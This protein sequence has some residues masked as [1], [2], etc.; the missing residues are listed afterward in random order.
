VGAG[1]SSGVMDAASDLAG[2]GG[3]SS[4]DATTARDGT[5]SDGSIR[6]A[7]TGDVNVTTQ[8]PPI[9]PSVNTPCA[10]GLRDDCG[11][12]PRRKGH[13]FRM[14]C[15]PGLVCPALGDCFDEQ[16]KPQVGATCPI[17]QHDCVWSTGLYCRCLPDPDGG[18]PTWDCFPPSPDCPITPLNKGQACD[19]TPLTCAYGTCTLG[20]KVTTSCVGGT[21][22]W[23]LPVCP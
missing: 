12:P 5:S 17:P 20:T 3:Q 11:P 16:P 2:S 22:R 7:L 19:P 13:L 15:T 10:D 14:K 1:G 23:T 8:C 6:D 18:S 4:G 9:E 21:V